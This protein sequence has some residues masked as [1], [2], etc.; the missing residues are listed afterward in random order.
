MILAKLKIWALALFG[1]LATL[2]TVG[3]YGRHKGK[4]SAEKEQ[5]ARDSRQAAEVAQ[6]T[7]QAG[8]VRDEI[9]SENAKLPEAGPQKVSE[10]DPNSAAG[11]LRDDGWML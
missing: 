1:I 3:F 10:A 9:E 4:V 6:Q 5:A 11:K 7:I 2:V 8:K